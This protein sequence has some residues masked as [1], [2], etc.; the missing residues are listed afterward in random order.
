M[1][2]T[3]STKEGAGKPVTLSPRFKRLVVY[4]WFIGRSLF[5]VWHLPAP[6]CA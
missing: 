6:A 4:P 5:V 3:F 1:D 2:A